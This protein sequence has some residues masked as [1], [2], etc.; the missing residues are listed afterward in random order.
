MAGATIHG[1]GSLPELAVTVRRLLEAATEP[2]YVYAYWSDVDGASHREGTTSDLYDAEL[3]A[4]C[5]TV[6]RELARVDPAVAAETLVVLTA[7]H[8]HVNVDPEAAVDLAELPA[9]WGARDTHPD[10][11][12]IRPTGGPRNVHLHLRDGA[13][14]ERAR[15]HLRQADVDARVLTGTEALEAELFGPGEP[16]AL[17]RERVGDLVVIPRDRSVWFGAEER[18]LRFVGTHGGQHPAEMTVPFLAAPLDRWQRGR[19]GRE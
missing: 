11:T 2:T 18:E 17:L 5:A 8:G 9:V 10:D 15:A 4:V 7:D 12:P 1:C 3:E 6:E 13:S 16:S 19:A 14:V